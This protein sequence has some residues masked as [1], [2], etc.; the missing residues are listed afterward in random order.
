MGRMQRRGLSLLLALLPS[1]SLAAPPAPSAPPPPPPYESPI[2]AW[3]Y[4]V[5]PGDTFAAIARRM[6]VSMAALAAENRVPLPYLI[7]QGQVLRRPS[8]AGDAVPPSPHPASRPAP[9][10]RP[11]P[12]PAP[13]ARPAPPLRPAPE[14]APAHQ[15]ETGAPRLSWPTSG[16][17]VARFGVRQAQGRANNGIDLAA[18]TG[19]SVHAA[20]AGRVLFA[21]TEPQRFGQLIVI[22][23]GGGWVTAYAYLGRVDVVEGQRVTARQPIARIGRSGE[24][25]K[26][27]L[28]FE[29]RRDNVPRDPAPYLPVRL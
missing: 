8:P 18:F 5:Q 7:T 27:T 25:Q 24:A 4:V 2:I 3:T 6:G 22:D 26:P 15:R 10:P 21:G 14:T 12:R 28:H 23:H 17:I 20:A 29:L 13:V 11:A 1:A 9:V 16:T 19:M